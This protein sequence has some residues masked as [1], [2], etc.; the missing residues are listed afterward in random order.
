MLYGNAFQGVIPSDRGQAVF[1]SFF[2]DEVVDTLFQRGKV[3]L[4]LFFPTR[5][6]GLFAGRDRR[7][8]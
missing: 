4:R 6:R 1:L 2:V 3:E 8:F 7:S 5:E